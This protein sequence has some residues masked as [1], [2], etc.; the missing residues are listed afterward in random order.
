MNHSGA[1]SSLCARCRVQLLSLHAEPRADV[2]GRERDA[3]LTRSERLV[4]ELLC[5]GLSN[6]QIAE[7]LAISANTVRYHLKQVYAK[8]GVRSRARAIARVSA[9]RPLLAASA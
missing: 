3:K 9:V 7:Q 8:L 1:G 2:P 5:E 6:K 4:F